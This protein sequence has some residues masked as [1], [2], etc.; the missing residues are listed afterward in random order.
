MGTCFTV[1]TLKYLLCSAK[2]FFQWTNPYINK[3]VSQGQLSRKRC[4]LGKYGEKGGSGT[5]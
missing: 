5:P 3:D 2:N 4:E 1:P